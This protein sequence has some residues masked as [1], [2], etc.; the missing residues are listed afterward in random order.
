MI[1]LHWT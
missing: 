1:F